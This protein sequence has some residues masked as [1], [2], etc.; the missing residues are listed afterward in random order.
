MLLNASLSAQSR[1]RYLLFA[2]VGIVG[3]LVIWAAHSLDGKQ[4]ASTV[5]TWPA[6]VASHFTDDNGDSNS[7]NSIPTS[8]AT[9]DS[10]NP[11]HFI[12]IGDSTTRGQAEGGGGWGDAFLWLLS[13]GAT[14]VNHGVNGAL[15]TGYYGSPTWNDAMQEVRQA[16]VFRT[17]YVTIQ[18]GTP[19]LHPDSS[20]L[21]IPIYP[22]LWTNIFQFGHNDQAPNSNVTL[23]LYQEALTGMAQ[24]VLANGGTPILVTPLARRDYDADGVQVVDNLKDQRERTLLA[25]QGV[26]QSQQPGEKPA[27]LINLNGASLAYVGAIG[28]KAAF[29]YNKYHPL[30]HDTTHLNEL[31][32]IVFGR[33]IADLMLGHPPALVPS[34]DK[35]AWAPGLG[36]DDDG[37]SN[38]LAPDPHL[39]GLVW[40]GDAI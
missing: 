15:S 26:L 11:P 23:D 10:M 9:T 33:I 21:I 30:F 25:Y 18:V 3:T 1:L 31:G 38:Y 22:V 20:H 4:L 8:N 6:A 13:R 36:N 35:D 19:I 7:N 5:G 2:A 32:A 37:L 14:G 28:K 27:R 24:D 40:H 12:L 17:V 39:T 29:R 34:G 16:A